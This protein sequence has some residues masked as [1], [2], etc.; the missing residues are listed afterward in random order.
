[1]SKRSRAV[2]DESNVEAVVRFREQDDEF[3]KILRAA[4]ERGNECCPIGVST[5][6]STKKPVWIHPPE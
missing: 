1:M 6:P 4:I 5:Q 3:C 2:F